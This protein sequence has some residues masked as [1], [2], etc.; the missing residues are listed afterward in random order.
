MCCE[1]TVSR[2]KAAFTAHPLV[3]RSLSLKTQRIC[4]RLFVHTRKLDPVALNCYRICGRS[5]FL[6]LLLLKFLTKVTV[7]FTSGEG[8]WVN[9]LL[10]RFKQLQGLSL[11]GSD[12][13]CA[14][15]PFPLTSTATPYAKPQSRWFCS[16]VK[17]KG[18]R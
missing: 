10:S 8:N 2:D 9:R 12:S 4:P 14:G 16:N 3:K 15:S 7:S 6:P 1:G 13:L 17:A 5:F 11:S 18:S